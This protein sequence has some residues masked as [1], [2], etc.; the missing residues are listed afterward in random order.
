MRENKSEV[1]SQKELL[2]AVQ[3]LRDTVALLVS[4]LKE[5]YPKRTEI[6]QA[7]LFAALYVVIGLV[8]SAI[9]GGLLTVVTVSGCFLSKQAL[10]GNANP[11]CATL[12][13]YTVAQERNH[14][15]RERFEH[16]LDQIDKNAREIKQL[17]RQ[18]FKK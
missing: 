3:D 9:V 17:Q 10:D 14:Q 13:G 5:D 11:L 12:P 18:H 4:T 7:R 2:T 8:V 6:K 16:V 15:T 1:Q